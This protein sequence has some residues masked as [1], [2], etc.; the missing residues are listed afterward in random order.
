M[1]GDPSDR[2]LIRVAIGDQLLQ[3]QSS[4][5]DE[6]ESRADGTGAIHV[7]FPQRPQGVGVVEG[8][9][10]FL[11]VE[12]HA[13][14]GG[15][16]VGEARGR[17]GAVVPAAVPVVAVA[18]L[19]QVDLTHPHR[20]EAE[21]RRRVQVVFRTAVVAAVWV[22]TESAHIDKQKAGPEVAFSFCGSVVV[23]TR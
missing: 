10:A 23:A 17:G 7:A 19:G 16:R 6:T 9:P 2:S 12:A 18:V 13:Q 20:E 11:E 22:V 14:P 8:H 5:P 1:D 15:Q 21:R 3:L 4:S